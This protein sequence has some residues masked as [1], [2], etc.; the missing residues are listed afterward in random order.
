MSTATTERPPG[1]W[2]VAGS[3]APQVFNTGNDIIDAFGNAFAQYQLFR[4]QTD[5][6]KAQLRQ[7]ELIGTVEVP[8]NVGAEPQTIVYSGPQASGSAATLAAAA[9]VGVALYLALS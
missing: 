8:Q 6:A 2:P 1:G 4:L 9:L 5:L 3:P 7:R